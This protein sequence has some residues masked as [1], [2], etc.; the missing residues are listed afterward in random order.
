MR[1]LLIGYGSIG[2]RHYNVLSK[3]NTTIDIVTKQ[4]LDDKRVFSTLTDVEDIGHYD[5]YLITSET[6]RHYE[7]LKYLENNV[8]DKIIFCEKPLFKTKK[9]LSV[10][11]NSVYVGY[12]LRFH[13]LLQKLRDLILNKKIININVKCG[14]YLP[15][16][17]VDTDYKKSYSAYKDKGGGVLLDLSHEIDYV[18]WLTGKIG[19][20]KS[21][22]VKISDLEIDSDDLTTFIGKSESGSIVNISID[23]ISKITHR[24]LYVD[25]I[26][27]SYFLDFINNS[28]IEKDK[29]GKENVF[30]SKQLQRDDI[31]ESMHK[32]ILNK[33]DI[34]STYSEADDVMDIITII[35][36]QN[37]V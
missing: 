17:R 4:T 32:S 31:F 29:N 16:W 10:T 24:T 22:Q 3:L 21:Y 25:T 34:A 19:D 6:N 20:I 7:E 5:Y 12:V 37:N 2:K 14:Q 11:R 15:T 23:Y 9:D 33:E 1:I 18:Q 35:Q 36:E 26:D 28:L 30:N 13:P 8:N 27:N